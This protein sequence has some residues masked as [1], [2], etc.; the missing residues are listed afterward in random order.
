MFI[1]YITYKTHYCLL[2]EIESDVQLYREEQVSIISRT[3]ARG[4]ILKGAS[5]TKTYIPIQS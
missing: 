2:H 1:G 4:A 3:L 5:L